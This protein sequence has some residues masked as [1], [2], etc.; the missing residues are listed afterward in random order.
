MVLQVAVKDIGQLT[1]FEPWPT[2]PS[3]L[4]CRDQAFLNNRPLSEHLYE[5]P[6]F[7]VNSDGLSLTLSD[8]GHAGPVSGR[9][10]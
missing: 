5:Q 3:S 10:G 9:G 4:R 8:I 2:R 7:D 6:V 1:D